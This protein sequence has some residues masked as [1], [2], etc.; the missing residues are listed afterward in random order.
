MFGGSTPWCLPGILDAK[1]GA[2]MTELDKDTDS[3][4]V[5]TSISSSSILFF[6]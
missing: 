4:H 6:P 5:A 2:S 3:I 1:C